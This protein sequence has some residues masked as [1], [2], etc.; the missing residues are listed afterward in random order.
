MIELASEPDEALVNAF[1]SV[2]TVFSCPIEHR[3]RLEILQTSGVDG[4]LTPNYHKSS[5]R[6]E[7]T[8]SRS[9]CRE[10]YANSIG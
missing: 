4:E 5:C 2:T 7:T 10:A 3:T 1:K 9:R 8:F 6:E